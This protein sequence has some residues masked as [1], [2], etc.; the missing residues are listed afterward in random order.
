[1]FLGISSRLKNKNIFCLT[2]WLLLVF[3]AIFDLFFLDGAASFVNAVCVV[4]LLAVAVLIPLRPRLHGWLFLLLGT[5]LITIPAISIGILWYACVAVFYLWGW[6]R[7]KTD[8]ALGALVLLGGFWVGVSFQLPPVFML[9]IMLGA[10]FTLG[11]MM[12]RYAKERDAAVAQ[13]WE[14]KLQRLEE[15]QQFKANLAMQ[16]HDSLAGTLSVVTKIAEAVRQ[17]ITD[18]T[19]TSSKVG[20]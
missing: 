1:M 2:F 19:S 12:C 13:L 5:V 16:L 11:S 15:S 17:E 18:N 9:L 20:F 7:Y 14:A 10:A 8:A 3:I 6:H 4:L